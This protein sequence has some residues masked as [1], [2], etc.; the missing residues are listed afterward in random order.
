M[1]RTFVLL[2]SLGIISLLAFLTVT[3]AIEEGIDILVVV[4]LIVLALL[5]LRGAGRAD[6]AALRW[7]GAVRLR[8]PGRRRCP[9]RSRSRRA[10]AGD[11][12]VAAGCPT[13]WPRWR[14]WWRQSAWRPPPTS[15]WRARRTGAARRP[16]RWRPGLR[17]RASWWSR[18]RP[19][20]RASQA[21][22]WRASPCRRSRWRAS[23]RSTCGCASR[24]APRW[25]ST[26]TAATRSGA[27]GRC[28]C[29]RWRA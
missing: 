28:A 12:A 3:V 24:P 9:R 15:A 18:R 10:A 26:S 20:S 2:G 25:C 23:T 13:C 16:F 1:A 27:A 8:C 21:R 14:C 11:A 6:H 22:S 4:S 7:L 5:G 29:C 17:P 19:A